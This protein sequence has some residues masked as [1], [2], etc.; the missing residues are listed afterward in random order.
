MDKLKQVL[1][2]LFLLLLGQCD[3]VLKVKFWNRRNYKTLEDRRSVIKLIDAIKEEG[4]VLCCRKHP[5][6]LYHRVCLKF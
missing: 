2:S 4:C 5:F 3:D 1:K 6:V